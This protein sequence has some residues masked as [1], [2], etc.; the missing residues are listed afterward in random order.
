MPGGD[1][2]E[3]PYAEFAAPEADPYADFD[4]PSDDSIAPR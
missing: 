4:A 1:E 2:E 3:D